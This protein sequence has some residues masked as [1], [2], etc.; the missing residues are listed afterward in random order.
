MDRFALLW[1]LVSK[2][3]IK[4]KINARFAVV[5]ELNHRESIF[6]TNEHD[7]KPSSCLFAPIFKSQQYPA[8]MNY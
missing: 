1:T 2:E 8:P 6:I 5:K 7:L 3:T 4:K